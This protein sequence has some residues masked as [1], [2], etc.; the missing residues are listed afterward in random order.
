[1][2]H[3]NSST[4]T[5]DKAS[6]NGVMRLAKLPKREIEALK[7]LPLLSARQRD[8]FKLIGKGMGKA[9]LEARLGVTSNRVETRRLQIKKKSGLKSIRMLTRLAVM[10]QASPGE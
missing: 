3:H 1:M 9:E 7:Q 4:G 5:A 10:D 6:P 2:S 8:A